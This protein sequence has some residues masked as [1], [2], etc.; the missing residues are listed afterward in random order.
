V[1]GRSDYDLYVE[2]GLEATLDADLVC[3]AP[4]HDYKRHDPAV[5]EAIRAASDRGAILYAH[6]SGAF[7][8]GAAGLLD[9]RECTTHWRYTEE[10]QET[11][12]HLRRFYPRASGLD[13]S[14]PAAADSTATP[15]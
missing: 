2:R 8:L 10:L 5:L 1:R 4:H 14:C 15:S 3:L 12:A 6:C 11:C 9:G 13:R 7:E